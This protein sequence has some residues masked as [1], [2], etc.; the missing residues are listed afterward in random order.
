M[1]LLLHYVNAL[2]LIIVI[3]VIITEAEVGQLLGHL[4]HKAFPRSHGPGRR[5]TATGVE[6]VIAPIRKPHGHDPP[7]LGILLLKVNHFHPQTLHDE[8]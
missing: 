7:E 2:L 1:H 3:I 5:Y 6:Y 4:L 8:L